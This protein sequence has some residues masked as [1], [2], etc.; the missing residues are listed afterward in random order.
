MI[1]LIPSGLYLAEG[2]VINSICLI[3]AEGICCNNCSME[4]LE[5]LPS[6]KTRTL[7]FPRMLISL[8][9]GS[10]LTVGML[11]M[12]SEAVV[13]EAIKSF[14]ILITLRS[15]FCTMVERSETTSTSLSSVTSS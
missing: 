4:T 9:C 6:T 7:L 12:I 5:G 11:F 2:L 13:P 8:V 14:P 1:P 3:D 10:I 15:I